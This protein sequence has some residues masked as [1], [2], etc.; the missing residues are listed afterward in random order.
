MTFTT[1]GRRTSVLKFREYKD[2]K[3]GAIFI[4]GVLLVVAILRALG[5]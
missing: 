2:I 5:G 1:S 3:R 4:G